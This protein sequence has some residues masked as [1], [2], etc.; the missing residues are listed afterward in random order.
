MIQ[1]GSRYNV[2][3]PARECQNET[4]IEHIVGPDA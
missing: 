2:R 3:M 4:D 1:C